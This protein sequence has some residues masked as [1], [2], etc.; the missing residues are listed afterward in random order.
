M[1]GGEILGGALLPLSGDLFFTIRGPSETLLLEALEYRGGSTTQRVV[2]DGVSLWA[3]S[4]SRNE[5][6][7]SLYGAFAGPQ[8]PTYRSNLLVSLQLHLAGVWGYAGRVLREIYGGEMA[9]YS[10]WVL[11]AREDI[12]QQGSP[13]LRDAL[14]PSRV[15]TGNPVRQYVVYTLGN[16]ARRS[17]AFERIWT[18]RPGGSDGWL[19][20]RIFIA[21]YQRLG[22]KDRLVD[23]AIELYPNM[24]PTSADF[25]FRPPQGSKPVSGPR[26][27]GG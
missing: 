7:A 27:I 18:T 21:E 5:Y 26:P 20:S 2:G 16:P 19:L 22:A 6:S 11:R 25:T 8:P 13:P 17:I 1:A 14:V 15:Y 9:Q 4:Y 23:V 3:Y 12:V 10:Q 24:V